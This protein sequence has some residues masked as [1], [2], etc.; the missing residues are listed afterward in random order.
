MFAFGG[1]ADITRL[2]STFGNCGPAR[3][4]HIAGSFLWAV[5]GQFIEPITLALNRGKMP[6]FFSLAV[7]C[8]RRPIVVPLLIEFYLQK[9]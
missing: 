7:S 2:Y 6:I 9:F 8:Q 4:I 3:I 1:K 5:G